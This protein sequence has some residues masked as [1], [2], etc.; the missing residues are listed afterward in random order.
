MRGLWRTPDFPCIFKVIRRKT[1]R[2]PPTFL[3]VKRNVYEF[4]QS[5][6]DVRL[7]AVVCAYY[8]RGFAERYEKSV[9]C[10]WFVL[11]FSGYDGGACSI[12]A[13]NVQT[14]IEERL[15]IK[16]TPRVKRRLPDAEYQVPYE[17]AKAMPLVDNVEDG[18]FLLRLFKATYEE[19][20][21][22]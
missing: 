10:S 17:G 5:V 7:R 4:E 13:K 22:K 2:S 21:V 8:K 9:L 1:L 6:L 12:F 3:C 18:Q 11:F 16:P 20:S 19:L 15:L 14:D